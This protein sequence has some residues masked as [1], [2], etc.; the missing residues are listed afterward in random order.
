MISQASFYKSKK[1]LLIEDCEP[2][3]ASIKGMLQQI[4]FED[5]TAVADAAYA[6]PLVKQEHFNFILAD[7]DLGNGKDA[8]QFFSELC[9]HNLLGVNCCFLL[10]SAEPRR[11]PVLGLLQ[12][13]PDGFLLKPFS[14]VD[15]EKRLAKAWNNR[16][17]LMKVYLALQQ[18]DF[19]NVKIQLD[20]II[21]A[22]N[23]S[24]LLALRLMAEVLLAE[25]N[26]SAALKLYEQVTQQRDFSWAR[27][28]QA[29]ALMQLEQTS[30]AEKQLLAL[31]ELD[32]M[33]PEAL[34]WLA[35]LY[36]RQAQAENASAQLSELLRLQ[37]SHSA[38]HMASVC[39]LQ[40]AGKTDAS[41][42]YW[43]KLIQQ[44]R[45]SAFDNPYYYFALT[46]LQLEQ[47][48]SA[49][50]VDVAAIVKKASDSLAMLPQK[51]NNAQ[52]ETELSV[53][54]ARIN[55]LQGNVAD[56]RQV[57]EQLEL[58]PLPAEPAALHDRAR[59]AFALGELK[60]AEHLLGKLKSFQPLQ[61]DLHGQCQ[62]LIAQ[63]LYKNEL[64]LRNQLRQWSQATLEQ[65]GQAEHSL[66]QL[67]LAFLYMPCNAALILNL[68]Q[69]LTKLP[70]SRFLSGV[71]KAAFSALEFSTKTA[72]NQQRLAQLLP[73][74]PE[75]YLD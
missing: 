1:V 31:S 53:L 75:K 39:A 6:L 63:Y 58:A 59:L 38:A 62:L 71:A 57:Y 32:D 36:L 12:G 67:S 26:F 17:K 10:F 61:A 56:A 41:V 55:L 27:L 64:Q 13:A 3:R 72:A 51:L 47:V 37:P 73:L 68:V 9:Q 21:N 2:V 7:F 74:L 35:C 20:K 34:E 65:A 48:F 8:M 50:A 40:L 19:A 69:T 52:T 70:E 60:A 25:S 54:R 44:Y 16:T 24:S 45:F 14:Y 43:Q 46:R 15:L 30:D 5:I 29:V 42:K 49:K 4:G 66:Q 23:S 18:K 33:R 28:G 11:M 22:V